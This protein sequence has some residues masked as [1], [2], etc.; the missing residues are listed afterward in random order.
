M[1][2]ASSDAGTGGG[3]CLIPRAHGRPAVYKGR[4]V[5]RPLF[6]G[7]NVENDSCLVR[8]DYLR[9]IE[10][11]RDILDFFFS[12]GKFFPGWVRLG[13]GAVTMWLTS[14]GC[15]IDPIRA[16]ATFICCITLFTRTFTMT[17]SIFA[18]SALWLFTLL[19]STSSASPQYRRYQNA[20]YSPALPQTYLA[21]P[22]T[23]G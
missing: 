16:S 7:T 8:L 17:P 20:S 4:A 15:V 13:L 1:L 22:V 10:S 9:W 19:I 21:D 2:D 11:C 5:R 14:V 12:W 3:E 18:V 6:W 23:V